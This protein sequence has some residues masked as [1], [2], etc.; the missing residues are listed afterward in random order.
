MLGPSPLAAVSYSIL[1]YPTP[2]VA[3]MATLHS[4]GAGNLQIIELFVD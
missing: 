3:G 1:L 2:Q 4:Y